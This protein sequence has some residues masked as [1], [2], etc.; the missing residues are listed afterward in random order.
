MP[1]CTLGHICRLVQPPPPHTHTHTCKHTHTHLLKLIN[2]ISMIKKKVLRQGGIKVH[3]PPT[4]TPPHTHT[5]ISNARIIKYSL[6]SNPK[7]N[8]FGPHPYPTPSPCSASTTQ[9]TCM[10][11]FVFVCISASSVPPKKN[12]KTCDSVCVVHRECL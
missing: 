10:Y 1:A 6:T 2:N 11:Q 5:L 9:C 4:T 3:P 8:Q 12:K 7:R